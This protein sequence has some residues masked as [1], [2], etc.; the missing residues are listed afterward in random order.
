MVLCSVVKLKKIGLA[1]TVITGAFVNGAL[2]GGAL[3]LVTATL[4]L[5]AKKSGTCKAKA[6]SD[7]VDA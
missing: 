2:I 6:T 3:A 5:N 1:K 4:A 7:G